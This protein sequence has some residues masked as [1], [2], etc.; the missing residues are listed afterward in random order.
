MSERLYGPRAKIARA[1]KHISDLE[2]EIQKLWSRKPY[3]VVAEEEAATGDKVYRVRVRENPHP[4]WGAI[5]GDAAHN[6][7]SAFDLLVWQLVLANNGSPGRY[8]MFPVGD[9]AK[10]Y[11]SGGRRNI[12]G[13]SASAK[14]AIDALK[15]YNG[16]N[17][18]LWR[19]H[20]L[21]ANDKHQ[22]LAVMGAAHQN[23][24]VDF[25]A[26]IADLM[27]DVPM[28]PPKLKP[29]ALRPADRQFPLEDGDEIFR[30]RKAARGSKL[31]DNVKFTFEVAISDGEVV[32]G[33]P[34]IPTLRH[35]ADYT[36]GVIEGFAPLL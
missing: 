4:E 6:L 25:T 33:E 23:I 7:R 19:L 11:E 35:I 17:D 26:T 5:A 10:K 24:V 22:L 21:D 34:V 27:K 30:I 28:P 20:R 18:A 1:N 32:E 36:E 31:D 8:T 2:A 3:A 29:L 12:K 13:V 14:K 9:S 16:G 15:P